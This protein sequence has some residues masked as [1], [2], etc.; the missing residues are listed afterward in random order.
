MR[1]NSRVVSANQQVTITISVNNQGG[2]PASAIVVRDTLRGLSFVS[3]PSNMS[4]VGSGSGYVILEGTVNSLA[5]NESTTLVFI[6]T[7]LSTGELINAAQI[8]SSG[9]P[10][11]D[12][13]PGSLTPTANNL[14]GE[15]D[16][17][18]I[19]FRIM[20]N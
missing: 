8:W 9:T 2:L 20:D 14:N 11:P 10:D 3:S 19:A 7:P 13:N 17:A 15:D 1:V 6:A 4:V 5:V 16:V 18:Q 12:S